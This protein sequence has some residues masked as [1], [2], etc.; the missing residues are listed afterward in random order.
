[1]VAD[2]QMFNRTSTLRKPLL[3]LQSKN[4]ENWPPPTGK[5]HS[6]GQV[7]EKGHLCMRLSF[8]QHCVLSNVHA[9]YLFVLR[10]VFC[11]MVLVS[12]QGS[13]QH[14]LTIKKKQVTNPS[15]KSEKHITAYQQEITEPQNKF[16]LAPNVFGRGLLNI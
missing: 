7:V 14:T 3:L 12:P 15:L 16:S 8:S 5:L 13:S 1:M 2:Y 4:G 11:N 10:F 6:L 9:F